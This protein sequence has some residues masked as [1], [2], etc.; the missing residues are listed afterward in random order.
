MNYEVFQQLGLSLLLGLLVGLQRERTEA[1]VA[2]IR[3]FPLITL[4]GTVSGLLGV[5]FGEWIVAAG[6]VA[7]AAQFVIGNLARI[8]AGDLDPGLTTEM[9][10]LLMYGVGA[11]L[12]IGSLAVAVVCGGA[13]AVL[14]QWK[15]P[16]HEFAANL[17][18]TDV[19]AIMQFVLITLVVLPVLPNQ[20]YGPF[21]VLN[22]FKLWLMVV[23][24]VGLSL[25]GYVLYKVLG[26][27][28]GTVFGG[29]LGGL[30]SSTVT[31]VSFARRS[32]QMLGT[33]ELSAAVIMIASATV[34]ARLLVLVGT[35]APANFHVLGPPL[36]VMLGVCGVLA[37][38]AYWLARSQPVQ[39]AQ[40]ENPA[41]LKTALVFAALYAVVLVAVAAAQS[42]FGARGLYAVAVLSGLPDMDAITI[43]TAQM[44]EGQRIVAGTG[45]RLILTA[46]L[47]NLAFKTGIVAVLGGG[48]LLR[49]VAVWFGLAAVGGLLILGLWPR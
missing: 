16:L 45:W 1:S 18:E 29:L 28:A 17:G 27:K 34:Y 41:E 35:V 24:I 48:A 42:Y 10:A 9:A 46:S 2:G 4:L 20:T 43:S 38:I 21:A 8:K 22:P 23:L 30:I 7:L 31:T 33:A 40:H 5:R 6:L 44:V 13:V 47:A 36:A 26:D 32:R 14:L 39:R 3:T 15:K 37:V 12:V 25:V 11:Y 19:K 49:R